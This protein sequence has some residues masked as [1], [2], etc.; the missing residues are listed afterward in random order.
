M[1][2]DISLAVGDGARRMTYAELTTVRGISLP[3]TRRLVL[4]H[5]WPRQTGNDGVVRVTVPL[6]ALRKSPETAD[7]CETT[8]PGS[9]TTTDPVP[10]DSVSHV[11]DAMTVE[12]VS[13][14]DAA[15]A[16]AVTTTDP[17]TVIAIQTLSQ[18]VDMLREDLG[19]ANS[20][21]L[22]ERERAGQAERRV[23]ELQ[24][25][26]TEERRLAQTSAPDIRGIIKE[27]IREIAGA[28][29]PDNR[30]DDGERLQTLESTIAALREQ[31]E[32]AK[33]GLVAERQ[34]AEQAEYRVDELLAALADARTAAMITGC[35]AAALR[36]QL[37]LLTERRP[38]WRRWFR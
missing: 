14:T 34:R 16:A 38:W 4:R 1:A 6:T 32:Y 30:D 29:P 3:S 9:I 21:L 19:I 11:T 20:F 2:S 25:L 15:A 26:L 22:A 7:F 12:R 37:A 35:E 33:S 24:A 17:L 5:R 10:P 23:D 28:A 27:V 18:A 36:I 13:T 31:V 8:T